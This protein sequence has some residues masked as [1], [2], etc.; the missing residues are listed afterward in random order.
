M[1][2]NGGKFSASVNYTGPVSTTT[3][4]ILPPV[5]HLKLWISPR[6]F[7]KI[8]YGPNE[9]LSGMGETDSWIKTW[10]RN[11][12]TLSLFKYILY[13]R[14]YPVWLTLGLR[15]NHF[16]SWTRGDFSGSASKIGS[17]VTDLWVHWITDSVCARFDP[18]GWKLNI[19]LQGR[20]RI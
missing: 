16:I 5:V 2:L 19:C 10:S 7:E 8:L 9:I 13:G 12:V 14:N 15:M 1:S 3:A 11:L 17:H 4:A 20:V 6:I 18:I